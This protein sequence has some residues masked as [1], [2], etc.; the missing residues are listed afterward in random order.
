MR[1]MVV[2]RVDC[3]AGVELYQHI[4]GHMCCCY[5]IYAYYC[6]IFEN[7]V[8]ALHTVVVDDTCMVFY[9]GCILVV[10][11]SLVLAFTVV[12]ERKQCLTNGVDSAST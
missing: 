12:V 1:R 7:S 10:A 2:W 8:A 9:T 3:C 5:D 4:Y 6:C 11:D